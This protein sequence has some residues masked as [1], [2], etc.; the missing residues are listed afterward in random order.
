MGGDCPGSIVNE[1]GIPRVSIEEQR[2]FVVAIIIRVGVLFNSR[3]IWQLVN[4]GNLH[5][6]LDRLDLS[7]HEYSVP[8]C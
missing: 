5:T 7:V 3:S 8:T 1:Q 2:V 6:G 4:Q